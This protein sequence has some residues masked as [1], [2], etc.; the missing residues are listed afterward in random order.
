MRS[1]TTIKHNSCSSKWKG[2]SLKQWT[3]KWS[4][5]RMSWRL[6]PIYQYKFRNQEPDV[7]YYSFA[8]RTWP[9]R[10]LIWVMQNQIVKFKLHIKIICGQKNSAKCLPTS[11]W[12]RVQVESTME[13]SEQ[14]FNNRISTVANVMVWHIKCVRSMGVTLIYLMST[15]KQNLIDNQFDLPD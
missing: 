4:N 9:S 15:S 5:Y 11:V 14:D 3:F 2:K 7:H 1:S 13:V 8:K 10:K 12:V 6:G